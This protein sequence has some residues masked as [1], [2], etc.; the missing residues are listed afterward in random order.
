LDS[1]ASVAKRRQ[2][3]H[4]KRTRAKEEGQERGSVVGEGPVEKKRNSREVGGGKGGGWQVD[5]F[6]GGA[7]G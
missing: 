4:K 7:N 1:G 3:R 6:E 5:A 2:V